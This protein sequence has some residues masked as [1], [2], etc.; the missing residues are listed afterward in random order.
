[1]SE[2]AEVILRRCGHCGG[3]LAGRPGLEWM[4]CEGCSVLVNRFS[5]AAPVIHCLRAAEE[6]ERA[7]VWLPCYR[8]R[9]RGCELPE[10]LWVNAFRVAGLR[11][12]GDVGERLTEQGYVPKVTRGPAGMAVAR[13]PRAAE[14]LLRERHGLGPDEPLP[15]S[16]VELVS[17]PCRVRDGVLHEP[18]TRTFY[19]LAAVYPRPAVR[20]A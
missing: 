18:V 13:G 2:I 7:D 5:E 6:R 20:R 10:W 1:L 4:A 19:P 15:L 14:R 3:T 11:N 16:S 12:H 8:F 9:V 17:L